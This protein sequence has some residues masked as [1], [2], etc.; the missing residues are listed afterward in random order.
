ME[1]FKNEFSHEKA[2][3]IARALK[4]AHPAFPLPR[5]SKGL[6][7]AL[8]PLELKQRMHLIADRIEACLPEDP[9]QLFPVLTEALS[10]D[11]SGLRGFPVWPLTEIVARRGL[12]HFEES[13]AALR[14]MTK[15]FTAEFAIRPFLRAHP[16]RTM[17]QLH[18]WCGHPDEHVRRC[19]RGA[20]I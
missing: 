8:A 15:R 5:F 9:R 6:E 3:V 2:L 14:E 13:M 16:E 11:S 10:S 17:K 20:A 19:S 12:G 4:R 1:P 18:A 7:E